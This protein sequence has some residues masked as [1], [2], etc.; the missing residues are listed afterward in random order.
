MIIAAHGVVRFTREAEKFL[1]R[2][3]EVLKISKQS[4]KRT[5]CIVEGI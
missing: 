4:A 3:Q 5:V 2:N 1:R